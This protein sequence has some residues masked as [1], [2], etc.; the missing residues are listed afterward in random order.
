MGLIEDSLI[1]TKVN[2]DLIQKLQKHLSLQV[3]LAIF[4]GIC[5]GILYPV[6]AV[7]TQIIATVFVEI[8]KPFIAPVIFLIVVSFFA[9]IVDLKAAG[10]LSLKSLLYFELMGFIAIVFG[11]CF[12]FIINPGAIN[13]TSFQ[14]LTPEFQVAGVDSYWSNAI[15]NLYPLIFLLLG[16]IIGLMINRSK[17]KHQIANRLDKIRNLIFE[18][19]RYIFLLAPLAAYSGIAYTVGKF[20]PESLVPIGKLVAGTYLTMFLFIIIVFGGILYFF[21]VN[22][23]SFLNDIKQE[24]LWVLGT[25]SSA[26]V[27]PLLMD[28][29]EKMGYKRSVVSLVTVTGNSFN[30]TGTSLYI[31]IAVIFLSQLYQVSFS[32]TEILT[33]I[34]IIMMTSK[35]ATGIAGTGFI[36][37]AT[38]ITTI[39][40]IPVEGLAILLSVDRFMSEARAI[41]N[42]IGHGVATVVMSKS[43]KNL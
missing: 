28:K 10:W 16:C 6:F 37:M 31:G 30:L 14:L 9:G 1:E 26:S 7:K 3:L 2:S 24:L 39:H 17:Y 19:L 43:E 32:F 29:L 35:G 5:T 11:I 27:L 22:I 41:T 34:L 4:L 23:I 36:A 13:L 25:S 18:I 21:K 15:L 33:I 8:I 40:K 38:T 42:T 12:T 20:G